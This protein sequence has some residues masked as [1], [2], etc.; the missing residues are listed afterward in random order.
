MRIA[1][2]IQLVKKRYFENRNEPLDNITTEIETKITQFCRRIDYIANFK[3][4]Y[5]LHTINNFPA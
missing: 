3:S 1:Y 5:C 4:S 2:H